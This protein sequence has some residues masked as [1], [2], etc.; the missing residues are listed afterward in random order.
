MCFVLVFFH[1]I[2]ERKIWAWWD[3][4]GSCCKGVEGALHYSCTSQSFLITLLQLMCLYMYCMTP[5]SKHKRTE[6][7]VFGSLAG[8]ASGDERLEKFKPRSSLSSCWCLLRPFGFLE[9]NEWVILLVLGWSAHP[10]WSI[11]L[12]FFIGSVLILNNNHDS[13]SCVDMNLLRPKAETG[14]SDSPSETIQ[15]NRGTEFFRFSAP[16]GKGSAAL[17][18]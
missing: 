4:N 13:P 9:H 3:V 11:I 18:R 12:S 16:V 1:P 15:S 2:S 5:G 17:S 8:V 6:R 7:S 10:A 14:E